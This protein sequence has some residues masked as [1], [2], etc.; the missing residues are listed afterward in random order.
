MAL[1]QSIRATVMLRDLPEGTSNL[2]SVL[3]DALPGETVAEFTDLGAT[4][5]TQAAHRMAREIP[6]LGYLAKEPR[7]EAYRAR[8]M[9]E[10]QPLAALTMPFPYSFDPDAGLKPIRVNEPHE[11]LRRQ[12]FHIVIAPVGGD[13]GERV[14]ALYQATAVQTA[15]ALLA[16]GAGAEGVF[17]NP[18]E[19]FQTTEDA[20][21][22]AR[23]AR[24]GDVPIDKWVQLF[25]THFSDLPGGL[26]PEYPGMLTLGLR[27]FIGRELEMAPSKRKHIWLAKTL[28]GLATLSVAQGRVF[29]DGH[30]AENEE[31]GTHF[32]IRAADKGWLRRADGLPALVIVPEDSIVDP[33]TL[34]VRSD[35]V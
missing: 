23:R 12:R 33:D 13:A 30:T 1:D 32:R 18:S 10:G 28:L 34:M 31:D 17:W 15:A 25:P 9:L 19:G 2:A 4:D 24:A 22:A 5:F 21:D 27:P 26:G 7:V 6:G 3:R 8:F 11:A 35:V 14:A 29:D 16:K 20:L